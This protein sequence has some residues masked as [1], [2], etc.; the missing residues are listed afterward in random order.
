[1]CGVKHKKTTRE[2]LGQSKRVS[3]R[4]VLC[5]LA[6]RTAVTSYKFKFSSKRLNNCVSEQSG[7]RQNGAYLVKQSLRPGPKNDF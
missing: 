3:I 4:E 2:S 6:T 1:M 5:F 7:E